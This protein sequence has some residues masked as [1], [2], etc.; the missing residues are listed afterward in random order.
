[1]ISGC[2]EHHWW[3][4]QLLNIAVKTKNWLLC[5]RFIH[6]DKW[7]TEVNMK[8]MHG[9]KTFKKKA[10]PLFHLSGFGGII[11]DNKWAASFYL[12]SLGMCP[13]RRQSSSLVILS[14]HIGAWRCEMLGPGAAD[15]F[16]LF[17]NE[18]R[19]GSASVTG[20]NW[21]SAHVSKLAI[22]RT[23]TSFKYSPDREN[24]AAVLILKIR[25]KRS[26]MSRP[27]VVSFRP[28]LATRQ[29]INMTVYLETSI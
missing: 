28:L 21:H 14:V 8:V 27:N 29:L 13:P 11:S 22:Y 26:N 2:Y 19:L 1:M 10:N 20:A 4:D 15:C 6:F 17:L 9:L 5:G 3:S 23:T 7:G 12:S 16:P 25:K 18:V 24:Q